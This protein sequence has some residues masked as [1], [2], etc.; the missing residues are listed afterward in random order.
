MSFL[1]VSTFVSK[2][3]AH[4]LAENF[5]TSVSKL[6]NA[7]VNYLQIPE[8]HRVPHKMPSCLRPLV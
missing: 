6:N 2:E 3:L 8:K 5:Q 1:A 4:S 7:N